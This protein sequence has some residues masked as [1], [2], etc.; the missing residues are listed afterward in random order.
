MTIVR[1]LV[2]NNV[3][4]LARDLV[5]AD[6]CSIMTFTPAVETNS[7]GAFSGIRLTVTNNGVGDG[8]YV[9]AGDTSWTSANGK[10]SAELT[11][12]SSSAGTS[13]HRLYL[14]QGV[15]TIIG[16]AYFD[17]T[18]VLSDVVSSTN[19]VT[20]LTGGSGYTFNI[21]LDQSAG[22]ATYEDSEGNSGSLTV[23]GAYSNTT[24]SIWG[25][26]G[27][28]TASEVIVQ[29]VNLG[30]QAFTLAS[31]VGKYCDYT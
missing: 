5:S 4:N 21:V 7:S 27:N 31:S 13:S 26:G 8:T 14:G 28:T 22:T 3:R 16:L 30:S 11:Y 25:V 12:I 29:D 17:S 20:G 1:N 2:R 6:F 15:S 19:L 9:T 10:V 23:D 18:K 24:A